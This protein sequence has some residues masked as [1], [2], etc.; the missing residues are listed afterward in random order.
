MSARHLWL[1]VTME[2]ALALEITGN[3][4]SF[5]TDNQLSVYTFDKP[6]P[7]LESKGMGAIFQKK[8]KK[9]QKLSK[10]EQKC[11]KFENILKKGR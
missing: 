9:R 8:G 7:I 5:S 1:L 2:K 11:I 6:G 10:F 4:F 3:F